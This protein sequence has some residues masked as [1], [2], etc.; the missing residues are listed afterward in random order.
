MTFILPLDDV[1]VFVGEVIF[2]NKRF[3]QRL[4]D[5]YNGCVVGILQ[6]GNSFFL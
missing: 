1:S 2:R 3:K 5:K 6:M 4:N